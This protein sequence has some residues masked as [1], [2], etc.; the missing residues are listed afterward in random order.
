MCSFQAVIC[1]RSAPNTEPLRLPPSAT[2]SVQV[3]VAVCVLN[4]DSALIGVY[5]LLTLPPTGVFP[6]LQNGL[7]LAP[8]VPFGTG[9]GEPSAIA[10]AQFGALFPQSPAG[11]KFTVVF[12]GAFSEKARSLKRPMAPVALINETLVIGP[13]AVTI[14]VALVVPVS[15]VAFA[16][17]PV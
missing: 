17:A 10:N 7:V 14:T 4:A 1:T 16:A 8:P 12:D 13:D 3:P 2:D 6:L 9:F 11:I 15:A 5:A